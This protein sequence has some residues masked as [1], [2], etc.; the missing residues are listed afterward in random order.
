MISDNDDDNCHSHTGL[1]LQFR[2]NT[3]CHKLPEKLI[4]ICW[5]QSFSKVSPSS[6][7]S[8]L[9]SSIEFIPH[10]KL[11]TW[12][13]LCFHILINL[14]TETKYVHSNFLLFW[15][16]IS[17]GSEYTTTHTTDWQT[18]WYV[19]PSQCND[20]CK[21]FCPTKYFLSWA[22]AWWGQWYYWPTPHHPGHLTFGH[23]LSC[24]H[25]LVLG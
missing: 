23:W 7:T 10:A 17:W 12:Q 2:L 13:T 1:C 11:L 20:Y 15:N 3:H 18:I 22:A 25:G 5:F 24:G 9:L 16:L 8:T 6:T 14:H 21:Y 19:G 4:K